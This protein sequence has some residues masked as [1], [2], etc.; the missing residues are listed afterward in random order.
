MSPPRFLFDKV[1]GRC[2]TQSIEQYPCRLEVRCVESLSEPIIN[3]LQT[4]ESVRGSASVSQQHAQAYSGAQLPPERALLMREIE[5]SPE[6]VFGR[7]QRLRCG[8]H[9]ITLDAQQL[10]QTPA[11]RVLLAA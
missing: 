4:R 6:Q 8:Q 3:R 9:K 10:G 2:L 5:R 11:I 7:G 1:R